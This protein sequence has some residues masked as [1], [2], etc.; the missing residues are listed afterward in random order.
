MEAHLATINSITETLEQLKVVLDKTSDVNKG[1]M[2]AIMKI[3]KEN[4]TLKESLD[5][6]TKENEMLTAA[7]NDEFQDQFFNDIMNDF[8][9][10][11]IFFKYC[12]FINDY[13][14]EE[15][16]SYSNKKAFA[17]FTA[18]IINSEL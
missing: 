9:F 5:K 4:Q 1:L 10:N 18:K 12:E 2:E 17:Y 13:Y 3:K 16:G 6:V 8:T 14:D 7:E 11:S 15:Y